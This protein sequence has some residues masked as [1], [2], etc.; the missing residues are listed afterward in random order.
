MRGGVIDK[1]IRFG[2]T[3]EYRA[4]RIARLTVGSKEIELDGPLSP[5]VR[6]DAQN[7]F[8]PA[9]PLALAAVA[10]PGENGTAHAQEPSIDLSWQPDN[11]ADLAGYI[12]Y[13]REAGQPD[14]AWQRVSPQEPVAGSGFHDPTVKVGHTYEYAVTAIGQNSRESD[15]SAIAQET[16]P[17]P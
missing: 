9:V 4:Q 7:V 3:Y 1:D 13:R 11:D 17:Q 15:K 8:A 2:E 16:V 6:I 12:V 10:V 5:P 14:S